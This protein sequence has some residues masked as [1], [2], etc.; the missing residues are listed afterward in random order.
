MVYAVLRRCL[1]AVLVFL[2]ISIPVVTP[3]GDAGAQQRGGILRITHR[4]SPASM[5]IHEEGTISV[6]L[7]MMGVFNN[8][9]VFDPHVRQNS[10]DDII[11]D[12]ATAWRWS[13]DGKTLTFTLRNGVTWHDGKPF[14]AADVKCTWDLLAGKAKENF[15]LNFRKGWYANVESVSVEAED[16]ASFHLKA[17]QPALL[18]LL[19]SGF[20][21]VYP[22][23][24]SPRDMRQAPI[25]T[26]PFKFVE[27]QGNQGIK[28]TR[29]PNYWKPG[30]P[31]LDGI[32]Y[33]II[34]NRSTAILAFVAGRFDMI[35]PY[36]LT[37]PLVEDVKKQMP[38]AICDISP[39][40][41]AANVL[42]NPVPPFDDLEVRRAVAMTIDRGAFID[43]LTQGK[44]DV[45]TAMQPLPE[46]RWGMPV[47][48]Q[49]ALPG[50]D[51][52]I[53]KSR[54]KARAIMAAHGYGPDRRL[55]LKL[56]S[57]NLP[58]YRDAAVILIG[59]LKEI[60][61][62][63]DLETVETALWVPKLI[64]RD[65]QFA[66]SQVGNGVDD[67]DQTYP[68]N[69]ACGSRTYMNY[70]NKEVDALIALQSAEQDQEKRKQIAWEIDRKLTGDAVRPI[71]YYMRGG[72]CWRP[73]VENITV[74]VNSIYNG[75]RMED[76]WLSR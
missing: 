7:P 18:A 73:G 10:L 30:L 39:M 48:M 17:P 42:M 55:S 56:S 32:E 12:L 47:E 70:C 6:V 8:L 40:N 63:A 43:I 59:Q 37:V 72:T 36:E 41:V 65:Y 74:M 13:E 3:S 11:P 45:G 33:T 28:L 9:V 5:S 60:Y 61:I 54:E 58:T 25:G 66:L 53:A 62:D 21:P 14:S 38:D 34:P 69:Y 26:G 22:C 29:N 16:Q 2:A 71:L 24:V 31:Y 23:H 51:P 67:P 68:E 1:A 44:G 27:Y 75:W 52:D 19:A 50:Y 4:D 49:Q 15:K 20:T 64:R 46:G 57:R 76:V 35:F